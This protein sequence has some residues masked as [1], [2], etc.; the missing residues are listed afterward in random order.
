MKQKVFLLLVMS[1]ALMVT[2][3]RNDEENTNGQGIQFIENVNG[4]VMY[5]TNCNMW[6]IAVVQK[7]N[8]DSVTQY[9]PTNLDKEY[10]EANKEVVFSGKVHQMTQQLVVPAGTQ[11]FAIEITKIN[12]K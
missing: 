5:N 6:Y 9:Y 2:G 7:G 8:Y 12:L 4:T 11:Y 3:C 1:V 10:Q